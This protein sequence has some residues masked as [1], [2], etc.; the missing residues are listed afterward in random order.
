MHTLPANYVLEEAL[1]YKESEALAFNIA[2]NPTVNC[3][4]P[5]ETYKALMPN[6]DAV[7]SI[8]MLSYSLDSFVQKLRTKR[9]KLAHHRYIYF[10]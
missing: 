3:F 5:V 1:I 9:V 8:M 2:T 4:K 7:E 10:T 6:A